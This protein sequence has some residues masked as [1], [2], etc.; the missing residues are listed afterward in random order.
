MQSPFPTNI[1]SDSTILQPSELSLVPI[2]F[3][4]EDRYRE[5][6]NLNIHIYTLDKNSQKNLIRFINFPVYI[7]LEL[8]TTS[9]QQ[10]I[11]EGQDF[12]TAPYTPYNTVYWDE[13]IAD[14]FYTKCYLKMKAKGCKDLPIGSTF[15][16]SKDIYFYSKGTKKAYMY[17]YFKSLEGKKQFKSTCGR[18]PV[19][20][21][22]DIQRVKFTVQEEK[23]TTT[24]RLMA[25]QNVRYNQWFNIQGCE[26][27]IN[28]PY[29]ISNRNIKEY[30]VDYNTMKPIPYE[31]SDK[32][33]IS[34][35]IAA[36]DFET[37]GHKGIKRFPESSE[38]K[39]SIYMIS[40]DYKI[41]GDED[42]RKQYCLVYGESDPIEGVE[43]ICFDNEKDLLIAFSHLIVY[44]CPDI[45]TSYNGFN[46]DWPYL[47][48][49]YSIYN[50]PDEKIPTFGCL[51]YGKTVVYDKK[52]ESSGNGKVQTTFVEASGI[53]MHD[54]L[55][56]I[57]RLFKLRKYS[58]DFV[59]N[60]FMKT[61]KLSMPVQQMF[62]AF[63]AF[64]EKTEGYKAKMTEVCKY[65][66]VDSE[67]VIDL[68]E[69]T[70]MWYYLS[71]ISGEGGVSISDICLRGEQCRCYSQLYTECTK[72]GY[73]ISNSLDFDYYYTGGFVGKPIPGVYKWVFTVDFASLYPSIIR[74]YN[75]CYTTYIPVDKWATIPVEYCE[76]LKIEQEE[77]VTHFSVS[78]RLDIHAK[79]GLKAT[80]YDV[81]ISDEEYDYYNRSISFVKESIDA[82]N[83]DE[84]IEF[85]V[86][87][88]TEKDKVLR[89]YEFRFIKKQYMEGFMPKLEREWCEARKGV[90]KLIKGLKKD[91]EKA[92]SNL[93][94]LE[95]KENKIDEDL[96]E[97]KKLKYDIKILKID[98]YTQDAKQLSIK[99]VANSGYGFT[100]VRKGMLSGVF[101]AIC[102][103]SMGRSLI[104]ETNRLLE[105]RYACF[106][107]KVVY[108][109]TDSSMVNLD[110]DESHDADSIGKDMEEYISGRPEKILPDGTI[111]PAWPPIFKD[112]LTVECENI[113]QICCIKPK[114]YLKAIRERNKDKIAI[115]GP[116][117]MQDGKPYI[118]KKGVLTAK[119]GNSQFTMDIYQDLSDFVLFM[120]PITLAIKSLTEYIVKLLMDKYDIRNF[121]KVTELG[122]NYVN[123][124]YMMNVFSK[125]MAKIGQPMRPGDRIEYI[126]V[127]TKYESETGK[128]ENIGMKCREINSWEKDENREHLDY[129]YYVEKGLKTQYDCLFGVGYNK[130]TSQ[131][132]Y[133]SLGYTPIFSRC[134]FVHINEPVKMITAL[135]KDLFIPSDQIFSQYL[136]QVHG[137]TYDTRYPRNYYIASVLERYMTKI[138]EQ[139]E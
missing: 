48:G 63:K 133:K 52:W 5:T 91:L 117:E 24:M 116:F 109:D 113:C 115:N 40:V 29:R 43:L 23:V 89:K 110:I 61:G 54:M 132:K 4:E 104:L 73:I 101:I 111:I 84:K 108:N 35:K 118:M 62:D 97:I 98:L 10:I 32:W 78:R 13:S 82:D 67:L 21:N 102:V 86:E 114:Y 17:I 76:V 129:E 77:P 3:E 25:R 31:I 56:N 137:W 27:P 79:M 107:A 130:I 39:D 49:R 34:P 53:I 87:D 37:Y 92:E 123:E 96:V 16:K 126:I 122:S 15:F 19:F 6:E 22:K 44:I 99:V 1:Y 88:L 136:Q 59:A 45:L 93:K 51:L 128:P 127:K 50:I 57:K 80:G 36:F 60:H 94:L 106:N 28:S 2:V 8:D 30:Y 120:K 65:C 125:N 7:C 20:V 134:H 58:L 90:K 9:Y 70:N 46:F 103:T 12:K 139:F 14:E 100:G 121:T 11:G 68:F 83:P 81:D 41:L 105:L 124:G 26:V 66:I 138:C 112:P 131:E 38:V 69:I 119:R 74:A 135:V 95:L 42:S 55:P 85:D 18:F 47:L 33:K 71:S 64:L 75:L 72:Q